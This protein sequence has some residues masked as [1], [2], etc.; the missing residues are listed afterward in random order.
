MKKL[1]IISGTIFVALAVIIAIGILFMH[2]AVQR[3]VMDGPSMEPTLHKGQVLTI[4]PY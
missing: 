4:K 3:V 2:F 1:L